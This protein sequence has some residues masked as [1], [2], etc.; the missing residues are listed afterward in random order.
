MEEGRQA[1]VKIMTKDITFDSGYLN[2]SQ[3]WLKV[4]YDGKEIMA[5]TFDNCDVPRVKAIVHAVYVELL[6]EQVKFL[7]QYAPIPAQTTH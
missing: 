7:S 3:T 2:T 1:G 5:T 4:F 6:K